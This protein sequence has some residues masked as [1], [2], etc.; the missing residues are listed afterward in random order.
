M[1][2]YKD[3]PF[4]EGKSEKLQSVEYPKFLTIEMLEE[5]AEGIPVFSENDPDNPEWQETPL[6]QLDLSSDKLGSNI[7]IRDESKN[8]TGTV[9]D[10]PAWEL[11]TVFR[12]YARKMLDQLNL[13]SITEK[14]I[15]GIE[16]PRFSLISNGNEA[17]AVVHRF[18]Q[19]NLPPPKILI[20]NKTTPELKTE[21]Q[22][23]RADIYE[24]NLDINPFSDRFSTEDPLTPQQIFDLT[25]NKNGI[26]ITSGRI[27]DPDARFY[28]WLAH[29]N[30]RKEPAKL[31]APFGSGRLLD[32][33]FYWQLKTAR[34]GI[35]STDPR[36]ISNLRKTD[37]EAIT[38]RI[39]RIAKM[40]ILGA[41]PEKYPSVAR[42]LDA[43]VR[44][45]LHY[46]QQDY[47]QAKRLQ[48][49]GQNSGIYFVENDEIRLAQQILTKHEI[50]AEEAGAA[51]LAL[52][53]RLFQ[54]KQI[55]EED[56][57]I[58]INTGKGIIASDF[59]VS[60]L[61]I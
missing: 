47:E 32:S 59:H 28:D 46:T 34:N 57:C 23:W 37:H 58:A 9:K 3:R 51:S 53:I 8:P 38:K 7:W 48:W 45:F 15:E 44:P 17:Y 43:P 16:V 6:I 41:M 19:H 10:R 27:L 1:N 49:T 33:I 22:K 55:S 30:F 39:Y 14:D 52:Y 36:L 5:W 31:L 20:P 35:E 26:D 56:M 61:T 40:D 54:K 18:A 11:A 4:S 2:E 25:E 21:M 24:V 42:S 60:H 13:G 29:E 50:L 12:D